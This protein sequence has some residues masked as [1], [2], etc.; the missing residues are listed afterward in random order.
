MFLKLLCENIKYYLSLSYMNTCINIPEIC[1]GVSQTWHSQVS[2]PEKL[3]IHRLYGC[4]DGNNRVLHALHQ[5]HR[6]S[7]CITALSP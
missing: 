6:S 4:V 1:L 3:G 2:F 7:S 5:L